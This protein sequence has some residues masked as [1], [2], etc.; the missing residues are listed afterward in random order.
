[1]GVLPR[2]RSPSPSHTH[3]GAEAG[4]CACSARGYH[5][6]HRLP[7]EGRGLPPQQRHATPLPALPSFFCTPHRA[8][9]R[10]PSPLPP[11]SPLGQNKGRRRQ[12]HPPTFGDCKNKKVSGQKKTEVLKNN[13]FH[14]P[15]NFR[16]LA[17]IFLQNV[18][19]WHMSPALLL[20]LLS[21]TSILSHNRITMHFVPRFSLPFPPIP[22]PLPGGCCLKLL[23]P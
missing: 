11:P 22:F 2:A 20:L 19:Q 14:R 8:L 1:M 21:H 4:G 5:S 17:Q 3:G 6:T 12:E 16:P 23:S 15:L 18:G 7:Q 10:P 9:G 13:R